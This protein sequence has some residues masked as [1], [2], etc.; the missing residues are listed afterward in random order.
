MKMLVYKERC[1]CVQ[2]CECPLLCLSAFW[3]SDSLAGLRCKSSSTGVRGGIRLN[4]D[5]KLHW[6]RLCVLQ[7]F[8]YRLDTRA[9]RGRRLF[10]AHWTGCSQMQ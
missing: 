2:E 6:N 7:V 10:S 1:L 5:H 4:T 8:L 3:R 9:V